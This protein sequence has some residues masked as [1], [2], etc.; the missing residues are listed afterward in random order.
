MKRR[1][2]AVHLRVVQPEHRYESPLCGPCAGQCCKTAPGI[3]HPEQ[4]GETEAEMLA[5]IAAALKT[6]QW[7]VDWWDGDP[8]EA[9]GDTFLARACYV[10]PAIGEP[11]S[12]PAEHGSWGGMCTFLRPTGCALEHDARP[13]ECQALK[14]TEDGCESMAGEK[15][16]FA[17]AWL[18][19]AHVIDAA[20]AAVLQRGEKEP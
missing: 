20:L 18:P 19:F 17:I 8:R 7:A 3:T 15:Q 13:L 14:P 9:L 1:E 10:R 11:F 12:Y 16:Q 2:H 5:N 4:W 6:G